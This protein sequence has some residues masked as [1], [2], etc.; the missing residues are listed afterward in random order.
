M[1]EN[2]GP[3]RGPEESPLKYRSVLVLTRRL[4]KKKEKKKLL[5]M[6]DLM[7][8]LNALPGRFPVPK[9]V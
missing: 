1:G 3:L 6:V 4:K 8:H 5:K 2:S 7:S 9:Q